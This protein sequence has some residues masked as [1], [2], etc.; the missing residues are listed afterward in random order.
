MKILYF[1]FVLF[2]SSLTFG[3]TIS[4]NGFELCY[5]VVSSTKS[6]STFCLYSQDENHALVKLSVDGKV[7]ELLNPE[8]DTDIFVDFSCECMKYKNTY[9]RGSISYELVTFSDDGVLLQGTLSVEGVF[10]KKKVFEVKR[11]VD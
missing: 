2:F 7:H 1:S 6:N 9:T 11:V 3:Q 10:S 8:I 5:D 4:E